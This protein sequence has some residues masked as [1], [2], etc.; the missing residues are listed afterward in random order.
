MFSLISMDVNL[1]LCSLRDRF[2]GLGEYLFGPR[3]IDARK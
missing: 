1:I 2:R 3:L